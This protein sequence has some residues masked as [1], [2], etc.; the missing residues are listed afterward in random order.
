MQVVITNAGLAAI[1]NAEATGTDAVT[2]AKIGVGSGKYTPLPT[3]TSLVDETK[4]LDVIE[5]GTPGDNAIHVACRDDSAD[6]YPVYEFG[7]YLEDGTLFALYSQQ[8]P[9]IQKTA[10]SQMLLS[11]D[12]KLEGVEASSITFGAVSYSFAAATSENAGIIEIATAAEVLAGSDTQRAVTPSTLAQLT[13]TADRAGLVQLA[14]ADEAKTGTDS[15]KAVTAAAMKAAID[16]RAAS[17]E[18]AQGGSSET[19]FI[20]P[21]SLLAVKA[22]TGGLGLVELATETEASTGTDKLKVVTPAGLKAA[23]DESVVDATAEQKGVVTFATEEITTAGSSTSLAVTPAGVKAA[24]DARAASTEEVK[25]GTEDAKFATPAALKDILDEI[26]EKLTA[27]DARVTA[28]EPADDA[29][30]GGEGTGQTTVS[31]TTTVTEDG[32]NG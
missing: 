9:I 1:V 6:S 8:D 29:S 30:G 7:L 19:S 4:Q 13:S 17:D 22:S 5:G 3:A 18:V 27:L 10:T 24:V 14:T 2:I 28:L 31:T 15:A 21:K 23:L 26:D 12:V 11:V 25:V 16:D 20:T 32:A